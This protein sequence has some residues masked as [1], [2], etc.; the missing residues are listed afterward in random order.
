MSAPRNVAYASPA[1]VGSPP[2]GSRSLRMSLVYSAL[3]H[4][5]AVAVAVVIGLRKLPERPPAYRVEL[6]GAAGMKKQMGIVGEQTPE[7]SAA[8][9]A[10]AP[11]A[12]ERP[13][14][15]T[16]V[17]VPKAKAK[18]VPKPKQATPNP[19]KSKAATPK[20]DARAAEKTTP[21]V[22]GSGNKTGKGTDVTNMVSDGIDFPYPGYLS[23]IVRQIKLNFEVPKAGTLLVAEVHF[24]IHRDGSVT[25]ISVTKSSGSRS[26]DREATGAVEA[27]GASRAFGALPA[28]FPDDVL[29]VYFTFSPEKPPA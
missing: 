15:V 24:L 10:E 7:A 6:I 27:A 26:F 20:T 14:E 12:A 22:A 5:G 11:K 8:A 17:A 2:A 28:G 1:N 13:P 21:P 3:L 23:G 25:D 9:K 4:V 19:T 29:P 16:K 18:P